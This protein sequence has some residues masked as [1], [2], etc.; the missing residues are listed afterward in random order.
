MSKQYYL[1]T[2]KLGQMLLLKT[3]ASKVGTYLAKYGLI[4][5]Q[6]QDMKDSAVYLD[7]LIQC[8]LAAQQYEHSLT[9]YMDAE[10]NGAE[11]TV[12]SM[13]VLVLP[14]APAVV[15]AAG[16]MG[17]LK[18]MAN[19]IKSNTAYVADDGINMGIEGA[20]QTIN[21]D[22]LQPALKAEVVGSNVIISSAKNGTQGFEVWADRGTGT[23]VFI[24]FSSGA[25]FT[26]AAALP[27]A[28]QTWKYKAIYHLHNEQVDNW[29]NVITIHV[30]A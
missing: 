28:A 6:A 27:A 17:R 2:S 9:E 10:M 30:G 12:G 11:G 22:A 19:T 24:G 4:N 25:K 23:F 5:A 13:P 21:E 8:Q 1:P 14:A 18:S 29:S 26:D 3:F 16:F 7:Y 20:E 15:P